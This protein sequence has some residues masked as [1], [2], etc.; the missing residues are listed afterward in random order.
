MTF[1][2]KSV[3]NL[4]ALK[5]NQKFSASPN[6]LLQDLGNEAVLLNLQPEEYFGLD[7]VGSSIW[8]AL[9]EKPSVQAAIDYLIAEYDVDSQQFQHDVEDLIEQLLA[10][11]LIKITTPQIS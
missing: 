9:T 7:D 4:I 1:K 2:A 3:E 10:H 8:Y 11:E 5:I 6:V